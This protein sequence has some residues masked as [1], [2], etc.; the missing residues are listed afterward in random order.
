MP[1]FFCRERSPAWYISRENDDQSATNGNKYRFESAKDVL[2]FRT[3][4]VKVDNKL[5]RRRRRIWYVMA[6][7]ESFFVLF[8]VELCGRRE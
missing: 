8:I 5:V 3:C 2:H 7:N 1:I 4:P 6:M